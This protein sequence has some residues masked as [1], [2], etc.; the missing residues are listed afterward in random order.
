[1]SRF[2]DTPITTPMSILHT[3]RL[4]LEPM[5]PEHLDGLHEMNRIP[6]VMR[7]ITGK[8][9]T[10]EQTLQMIE[11]VMARWA[12]WGTSWW[13]LIERDS[14]RIVGAG[15]IQYLARDTANPLEIG[16]RLHPDCWGKGYASE[17][18]QVM[19]D[20][21]FAQLKA[22]LL[23]AVCHVDNGASARV[24]QRLGMRLKGQERW[25]DMDCH[26]YEITADEWARSHSGR[27]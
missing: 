11:R 7:Y 21:A 3:D 1:M 5:R 25:Y 20:F 10:R 13:S 14:G 12:E 17:A 24:M 16:W 26:V 18:A 9:E 23:C 2:D 8:P 22:P 19:A 6:E 4:R 15:C 27:A